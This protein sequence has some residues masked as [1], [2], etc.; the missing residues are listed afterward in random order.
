MSLLVFRE[1]DAA[2]YSIIVK[3][4]ESVVVA[5]NLSLMF[6]IRHCSQTHRSLVEMLYCPRLTRLSVL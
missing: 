4:D 2:G 5:V 3:V 1:S 6:L